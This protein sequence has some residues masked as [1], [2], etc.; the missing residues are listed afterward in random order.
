MV[1][2]WIECN[3]KLCK[4]VRPTKIS[5]FVQTSEAKFH[6][7]EVRAKGFVCSSREYVRRELMVKID[8]G[9]PVTL[10]KD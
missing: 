3:T 6:V 8:A 9:V 10:R 7:S 1:S 4:D 5:E 2:V